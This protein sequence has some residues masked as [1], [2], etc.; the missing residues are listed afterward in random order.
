MSGDGGGRR[1]EE[2]DEA[3]RDWAILIGVGPMSRERWREAEQLVCICLD[4]M[5]VLFPFSGEC[6]PSRS[7]APLH[8]KLGLY[9]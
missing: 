6:H 5:K 2:G 4:M 7:S 9:A 1:G 3:E 8:S